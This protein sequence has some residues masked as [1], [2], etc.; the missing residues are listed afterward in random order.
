M[1]SARAI[2]SLLVASDVAARGLDIPAVSHIFNFDV[3]FHADDYVHR[4]GRTGRAGRTGHAFMLVTR[5]DEK[6]FAAIE[7]LT[8]QPIARRTMDIPVD[9]TRSNRSHE[10]RPLAARQEARGAGPPAKRQAF[11]SG[12]SPCAPPCSA[13][14]RD[15]PQSPRASGTKRP[16]P[17]CTRRPS[18][19]PDTAVTPPSC[20]RSC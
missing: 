4:I 19:G 3:P 14:A 7:K 9:E 6:S 17:A 13:A 8:G 2:S 12:G 5:R 11:P 18:R 20:R 1:H 16:S 10:P 15:R